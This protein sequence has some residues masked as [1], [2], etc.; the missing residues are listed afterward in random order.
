MGLKSI[1]G[2][3]I[4]FIIYLVVIVLINVAGLT[5]FFRADLTAN[6]LYSISDVSREVVSTLSEPL[7]IKVFFTKDLPAPYNNTERYL[8][9]LLEEYGVYANRFFNYRFYDVSPDEGDI[10]REAKGNRELARSYGINPVQ[11]Q[12]VDKDQ[13]K[14]QKAYMGLVLIHGDIIE[15]I[16]TITTTDGLEYSLTTS[17]QKL[18]NKVSALLALHGKISVKLFLSSSLETVAPFM[19]LKSLPELPQKLKGIVEELNQKNY[20]KLEFQYLDP[21]KDPSLDLVAEKHNLLSLK[22]PALSEGKIPPGKG[23]IGLVMAYGAKEVELPLVHVFRLP[24]IGTRYE[25][26]SLDDLK[27]MINDNMESLIDINEHLGYLADHGTFD[28]AASP[29]GRM[30]GRQE[31]D[32]SNFV[33]LA[34]QTYTLKPVT[35]GQGPIPDS[36]NCLV[37]ARPTETFTDYELY[38]IDQYL[39]RGKNLAIFLDAFKEEMPSGNAAYG[40][41][42]RYVP[43]S[44]GL[45]KLLDYYGISIEKS[46]VMDENCFKQQLPARL[47]GGERPIYFAPE[48]KNQEINHGIPAMKNIKGLITFKIS[49]LELNRDRIAKNGLK[50][51]KLFSSSDKSWEMSGRINFNPMFMQPPPASEPRK[52]MP[53]AYMI[54]GE[55]PSYF[56]GKPIPEKKPE[57]KEESKDKTD[58]KSQDDAKEKAVQ[59]KADVDLSKIQGEGE[60]VSKG[61]PGKIF[62]V[63]SSSMIEDSIVDEKGK[64]PNAAF[65]L[66]VIDSLN[67]RGEVAAMRSKEQRFNP[68]VETDAGIKTFV[69]SF[70]I[71]GLPVIVV[72]FGLLVWSHRRS[73][74]RRIQMMFQKQG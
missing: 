25:M 59:K 70:N 56:A 21:T 1:S 33:S 6:R 40:Q 74:K 2:K 8:H 12:V 63:A 35:L 22:W 24:I 14:F 11:I 68:L 69:K 64:T 47:G 58:S 9:D 46:Y 67:N 49:P 10:N 19:Q 60:F 31:S 13:I 73:R 45:E 3:Y 43:L 26:V 62:L 37:I 30:A 4:K 20:G 66:N 28:M 42:P 39:M 15:R 57:K 18:N 44:T 48:I 53:L 5:L 52:S 51:Y 38:Q 36:L 29:Y 17:I 50:A 16:P 34:S 23:T 71:A 65:I 61:K 72:F 7:T 32:V 55:F 54:E 27:E 41:G